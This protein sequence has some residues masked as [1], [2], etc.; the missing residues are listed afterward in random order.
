MNI[1][2][3]FW[4]AKKLYFYTRKNTLFFVG[5]FLFAISFVF[6]SF[7]ALFS[8]MT[9]QQGSFTKMKFT[10]VPE[11]EKNSTLSEKKA[12]LR[13][14]YHMP[15][16]PSS[17]QL[18]KNSSSH[19]LSENT[20]K[21]Q[22]KLAKLGL[23]DGP[24]DGIEGP[25]TRRAITLWRQQTAQEMQN[26]ISPSTI[27]DEIAILIQQSEMENANETKDIPHSTKPVLNSPA[28]DIIQVQKALRIFGNQEVIVTGVEDKKTREALKQFQKMFDLPIT[29]KIDRMVLVKM[30]E[31]GLLN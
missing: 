27:T 24:L 1:R 15:S 21:M 5:F 17:N 20:L 25:K 2:F 12:K 31:V 10:F 13:A 26:S 30:R 22:N 19:S 7:N 9:M 6:V 28:A 23:Y 14:V 16:M 3:L 18:H 4:V 29:G 11:I 8:Q